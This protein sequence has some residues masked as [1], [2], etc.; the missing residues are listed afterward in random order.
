MKSYHASEFT[1]SGGFEIYFIMADDEWETMQ[2]LKECC[3]G[4]KIVQRI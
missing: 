3:L 4:Q 1:R 2:V